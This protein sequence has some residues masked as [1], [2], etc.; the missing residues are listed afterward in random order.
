MKLARVLLWAVGAVMCVIGILLFT[1]PIDVFDH[2]DQLK[3]L[4]ATETSASSRVVVVP[5]LAPSEVADQ[6]PEVPPSPPLQG[7]LRRASEEI[8]QQQTVSPAVSPV[9]DATPVAPAGIAPQQ[10]DRLNEL[11]LD[12]PT[13]N[14]PHAIVPGANPAV[15]GTGPAAE[16]ESPATAEAIEVPSPAESP[17]TPKD[18]FVMITS[19]ASLRDGPSASAHLIGRA[20]AGARAR[21]ASRDSGWAQIVDPA[22]GN[23]GWVDSNVLVPSA[24]TET[25]ATGEAP[26]GALD[27]SL[28]DQRAQTSK[29][30]HSANKSKH[31]ANTKHRRSNYH[32]YGRR[33]F[34]FRFFFRGFRR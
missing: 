22:S 5:H 25:A 7:V 3:T 10:Q 4:S 27:T 18:E 34:A 13:Q 9:Q 31:A 2:V 19:A 12:P 32:Y 1:H 8:A 15:I 6:Q 23:T 11:H 21:V 16:S 24:T 14:S 17:S 33:R 28:E 26:D 30:A 29:K 20:Y